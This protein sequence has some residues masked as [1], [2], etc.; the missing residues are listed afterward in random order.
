MRFETI[1][2]FEI[3]DTDERVMHTVSEGETEA[4]ARDHGLAVIRALQQ[5]DALGR[6]TVSWTTMCL[7]LPDDGTV[8]LPLIRGIILKASSRAAGSAAAGVGRHESVVLNDGFAAACST[9]SQLEWSIAEIMVGR[10]RTPT[11]I[12]PPIASVRA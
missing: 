6:D 12:G 5:P 1:G 3:I 11:R 8:G 9:I 2:P 4:L 7:R 10:L